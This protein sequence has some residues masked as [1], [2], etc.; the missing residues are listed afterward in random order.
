VG[1]DALIHVDLVGPALFCGLFAAWLL[2]SGVVI[3][4][5]LNDEDNDDDNN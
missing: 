5:L 2:G 4:S 3:W 1:L